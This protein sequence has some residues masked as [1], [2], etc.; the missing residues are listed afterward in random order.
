MRKVFFAATVEAAVACARR[1]LGDEALLVEVQQTFGQLGSPGGYRVLFESTSSGERSVVHE[2]EGSPDMSARIAGS[3]VGDVTE[4]LAR[5][6]SLIA[7]LASSGT[8]CPRTPELTREAARLRSFDLPPDCLQHVLKRVERRLGREDREAAIR[9]AV[10]EELRNLVTFDN[11]SATSTSRAVIALVGPP[12]AGKTTTLVKLAMRFGVSARRPALVLTTDTYRVAAADQLRTYSSVLGLP[13]QLIESPRS[14]SSALS[15]HRQKELVLIDTPGFGPRDWESA[16]EWAEM[17]G[18]NPDVCVHLVLPATMRASETR[19]LVRRWAIF[20]PNRLIFT[21]M[22]ET[23]A[24]GGCVGAALASSTPLS[25]LG[26]G[27]D[28]PEDLELATPERIFGA[29]L[30]PEYNTMAAVA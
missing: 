17:L 7:W 29:L 6:S 21:R 16:S 8:V 11:G 19:D 26:T 9:S 10:I 23:S 14:L 18:A 28:I 27:Q 2:K 22:D 5:L 3:S 24:Y 4:E 25:W 1:D 12:G 13:F 30:M 15:E 20:E